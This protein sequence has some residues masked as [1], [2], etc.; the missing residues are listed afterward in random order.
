MGAR[1]A[2]L[3]RVADSLNDSFSPRESRLWP[4][5]L[6]LV[7]DQSK[8]DSIRLC[9]WAWRTANQCD[10]FAR[11]RCRIYGGQRSEPLEEPQAAAGKVHYACIEAQ[12]TAILEFFIF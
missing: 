3:R 5:W 11:C 8:R 10:P 12:L 4:L 9:P 7:D 6:S 2:S 1:A